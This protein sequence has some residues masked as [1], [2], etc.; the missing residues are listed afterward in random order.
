MS[1]ID[2]VT[3]MLSVTDGRDKTY[4]F[5]QGATKAL[6]YFSADPATAGK[7]DKVSK[8]L[9]EGRSIMRLGKWTS[10]IQKI[11]NIHKKA[12]KA[13]GYNQLLVVELIRVLGDMGYVV[14]DNMSY[15]SKYRIL[16]TDP[17]QCT[18]YGKISQFWG[19]FCQIILDVVT[20]ISLDASKASY[21][22]DRTTAILNITKNLSDILVILSV[23][24]YIPKNVYN[25]NA[26]VAGCLLALSGGI[27]TYQNWSKAGPAPVAV[28]KE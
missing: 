22:A 24:G 20:I 8:S 2:Q 21:A 3:K 27:A 10:N 5:L 15:L 7:I 14:G 4:K 25:L 19:F 17:K 23:V 28:K 12:L 13:G 6:A 11:E 9:G 16:S 18:K 26:G 1:S